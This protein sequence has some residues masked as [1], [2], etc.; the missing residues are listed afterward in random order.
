MIEEAIAKT[1]GPGL[2]CS[3]N[4]QTKDSDGD[5]AKFKNGEFRYAI[6]HPQ[7]VMYGLTMNIAR[8]TFYHSMSPSYEQFHQSRDRNKRLG[9]KFSVNY[10]FLVCK[11][12]IDEAIAKAVKKKQSVSEE[13]MN[14]IRITKR[15]GIYGNSDGEIKGL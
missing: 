5:I 9:Q 2:S 3:L 15:G 7:S 14:Y 4:G 12:T 1:F 10:R 13:I 6:C 8:Y 11:G